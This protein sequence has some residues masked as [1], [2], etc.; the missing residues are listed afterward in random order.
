MLTEDIQHIEYH[1]TGGR[2]MFS[3]N[4]RSVEMTK[5]YNKFEFSL[6]T[7]EINQNRLVMT[8]KYVM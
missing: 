8:K 1:D 4:P 3:G 5:S 2:G 6:Y 7:Y